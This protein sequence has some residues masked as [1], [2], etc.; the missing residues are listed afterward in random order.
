MSVS[1]RSITS[2]LWQ[3][4]QGPGLERFELLLVDGEWI[5][6][7]T[8]ISM[9]QGEPVEARYQ[10]VCD[11][12]FLT[13]RAHIS[14]RAASGE[15]EVE[16]SAE[17]GRWYQNGSENLS[18]RGALDIDLGWSPSTNMLPIRRLGLRIGQSSGEFTAAWV[19][20]PALTLEPL[21][22]EYL[23]VSERLYR[24]SSRGGRFTAQLQVDDHAIVVNYEGFWQRVTARV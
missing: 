21:P 18:V 22:Q 10:L 3:W 6:H 7:G 19:R 12:S 13:R 15:H 20:F 24:Y 8:I 16:I 4:L 2:G 23:R 1:A 14:V 17:N 11:S 9:S 5:L